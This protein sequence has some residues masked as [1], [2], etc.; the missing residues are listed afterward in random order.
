MENKYATVETVYKDTGGNNGQPNLIV[1]AI[2]RHLYASDRII[3]N[4]IVI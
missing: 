2:S 3:F 1:N 4:N